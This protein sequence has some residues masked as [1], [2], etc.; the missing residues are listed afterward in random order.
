MKRSILILSAFILILAS[1]SFAQ[2]PP[3]GPRGDRG[4]MM[5]NKNFLQLSE[6]QQKQIDKLRLD[7]RKEISPMQDKARS[8]N[9]A[10]RLMIVDE[11]ISKDQLKK[12]LEKISTVRQELALKRALHQRQVRELLTDEQKV[13]FDQR[14]ISGPKDRKRGAFHKR[15]GRMGQPHSLR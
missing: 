3:M 15:P 14:I 2:Q 6:Q 4:P 8:L 5:Q 7:F 1:V 9:N 11:K 12:Q 10:Y 13:K